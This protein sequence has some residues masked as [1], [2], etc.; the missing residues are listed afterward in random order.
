[1]PNVENFFD[2][3]GKFKTVG[4]D[5]LSNHSPKSKEMEGL[6]QPCVLYNRRVKVSFHTEQVPFTFTSGVI[7]TTKE[8]A[9]NF[10][11][12]YVKKL[13]HDGD[14]PK[15]VV[16]EDGSINEDMVK[17]VMVKLEIGQLEKAN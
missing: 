2:K 17:T 10:L 13:I 1:M 11:P 8:E 15:D 14:L 16:N 4:S 12:H 6:F 7:F 5:I 9:A 3:S